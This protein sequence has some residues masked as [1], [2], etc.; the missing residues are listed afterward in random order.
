MPSRYEI[1]EFGTIWNGRNYDVDPR[2]TWSS[3][4]VSPLPLKRNKGRSGARKPA[5]EVCTVTELKP[6]TAPGLM[7]CTA[8]GHMGHVPGRDASKDSSVFNDGPPFL[9]GDEEKLAQ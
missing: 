3:D 4:S 8:E 6:C 7:A 2:L 5:S 1:C 9:D